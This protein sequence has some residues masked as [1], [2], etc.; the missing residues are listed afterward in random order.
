ME[1]NNNNNSLIL[2]GTLIPNGVS[3]R[4]NPRF[5]IVCGFVCSKHTVFSF[6]DA[7]MLLKDLN[8]Q[9]HRKDLFWVGDEADKKFVSYRVKHQR[10]N[11]KAGGD[12]Y[13]LWL[14]MLDNDDDV[15]FTRNNITLNDSIQMIDDLLGTGE[16]SDFIDEDME[17]FIAKEMSAFTAEN[18]AG[19]H[20]F[21]KVLNVLPDDDQELNMKTYQAKVNEA[22]TKIRQYVRQRDN[23]YK[24]LELGNKRFAKK[25]KD[26]QATIRALS[27]GK[28]RQVDYWSF[29]LPIYQHPV[30]ARAFG[31]IQDFEV[32][33]SESWKKSYFGCELLIGDKIE[34]EEKQV[35]FENQSDQIDITEQTVFAASLKRP[36]AEGSRKYH[37]LDNDLGLYKG[38]TGR[39]TTAHPDHE[40][41]F[42]SRYIESAQNFAQA[43]RTGFEQD[44]LGKTTSQGIYFQ[45]HCKDTYQQFEN[46]DNVLGQRVVAIAP[47]RINAE[48]EQDSRVFSLSSRQVKYKENNKLIVAPEIEEG[49][50]NFDFA[51]KGSNS[52]K[53]ELENIRTN[54]L[55]FWDGNN[56]GVPR[57]GGRNDH[58]EVDE[59][60]LASIGMDGESLR[61]F[62]ISHE[63]KPIKGSNCRLWDK[64]TYKFV[65]AKV[66][67]N[68]W[69]LPTTDS[70]NDSSVS[71]EFLRQGNVNALKPYLVKTKGV[72]KDEEP[73]SSYKFNLNLPID[74]PRLVSRREFSEKD[75]LR[76]SA[77]DICAGE[78]VKQ[79]DHKRYIQPPPIAP[80]HA[81]TI[82]LMEPETVFQSTNFSKITRN[83]YKDKT[84]S[85]L[86][87]SEKAPKAHS[88]NRNIKYL[89]D[90][91]AIHVDFEASDWYSAQWMVKKVNLTGEIVSLPGK[92]KIKLPP[93]KN[94]GT[95][96]MPVIRAENSAQYTGKLA[97]ERLDSID[98][99]VG[100]TSVDEQSGELTCT[101]NG[102]ELK[103]RDGE[104][105]AL[106]MRFNCKRKS[107]VQHIRTLD[108]MYIE[109]EK[110]LGELFESKLKSTLDPIMYPSK[111]FT[112]TYL[113][114][115]PNQ[116]ALSFT[117]EGVSAVRLA[118]EG[119]SFVFAEIK[120]TVEQPLKVSRYELFETF[121]DIVD[122][123]KFVP[124]IDTEEF[125][126]TDDTER[127]LLANEYE[128]MDVFGQKMPLKKMSDLYPNDFSFQFRLPPLPHISKGMPVLTFAFLKNGKVL[129]V[130][131]QSDDE[132]EIL[133]DSIVIYTIKRSDRSKQF[134]IRFAYTP[135]I[136][137]DKQKDLQND[138]VLKVSVHI[139][140]DLAASTET[141]AS[142]YFSHSVVGVPKADLSH[143]DLTLSDDIQLTLHP[144]PL[145]QD[146][147]EFTRSGKYFVY[148]DQN[149]K[150]ARKKDCCV[151]AISRHSHAYLD[152]KEINLVSD[153]EKFMLSIPST[154]EL[155]KPEYVLRPLIYTSENETLDKLLGSISVDK[156]Y[157]IMI[158]IDRP[159]AVN[160]NDERFAIVLKK[161]IKEN[162]ASKE[163]IVSAIGRDAITSGKNFDQDESSLSI[164]VCDSEMN[165]VKKYAHGGISC[166]AVVKTRSSDGN[167]YLVIPMKPYYL[168]SKDKYIVILDINMTS[169]SGA[170]L[171]Y[172]PML[173]L[174]VG[175]YMENVS[176]EAKHDV[177]RLSHITQP[178]YM[179]L[180]TQRSVKVTKIDAKTYKVEIERMPIKSAKIGGKVVVKTA[181]GVT[182]RKVQGDDLIGEPVK[183]YMYVVGNDGNEELEERE[184]H[185][186]CARAENINFGKALNAEL[187]ITDDNFDEDKISVC[188]YEYELFDSHEEFFENDEKMMDLDTPGV[189]LVYAEHIEI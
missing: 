76:Q 108:T 22:Y 174:Q 36:N 43:G 1:N 117:E 44:N 164:R 31:L 60:Q 120:L 166:D 68:G 70:E 167:D 37:G 129:T 165:F 185:R 35:G 137:S 146:V 115:K 121:E 102:I 28:A 24:S 136:E 93:Y 148:A 183:T 171:G 3:R 189:R 7:F 155:T 49:W 38:F 163:K 39:F 71:I 151:R 98:F 188:V 107:E 162:N 105:I 21:K 109:E 58:K 103:L 153:S 150:R 8:S 139:S 62:G 97:F 180:M 12:V 26:I 154:L 134:S 47:T 18:Q 141:E 125:T 126:N 135:W 94:V 27:G 67:S 127:D 66:Y 9:M 32:R 175:K 133:L 145:K 77:Y 99:S 13:E 144:D 55:W 104:N 73:Y 101:A 116:P 123:G 92:A 16:A 130:I 118:N 2:K 50:L 59:E 10:N 132:L 149:D 95:F 124:Q 147:F 86:E 112:A 157:L 177:Q 96:D 25:Q 19:D 170:V 34:C 29:M 110:D 46:E 84:I 114:N 57:I 178:K 5:S 23:L 65:H 91:R 53:R 61:Q 81:F 158:E 113:I 160:D 122:N 138:L 17:G 79:G 142:R 72:S 176:R 168:S 4:G 14:R 89:S 78:G 64:Q 69:T 80:N 41:Q 54:L 48:S 63:F 161:I 106:N 74:P 87:Q 159:W 51:L 75:N 172:N 42:V 156:Q 88:R 143:N 179:S 83:D 169:K 186:L 182:L 45:F 173:K 100:R 52:E 119:E 111:T 56:L 6:R 90:P 20:F 184:T 128:P 11:F 40:L 30:L 15:S 140:E 187:K 82:G 33:G 152:E 85:L 181:F 131:K